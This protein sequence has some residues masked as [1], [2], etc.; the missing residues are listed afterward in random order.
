MF[1]AGFDEPEELPLL[2]ELHAANT[3]DTATTTTLS[4]RTRERGIMVSS[5]CG[6]GRPNEPSNL[7]GSP[8]G[9]NGIRTL[10]VVTSIERMRGNR[11]RRA[12]LHG[13]SAR[14]NTRKPASAISASATTSTT[15][16]YSI[17]LSL[18]ANPTVM[19]RPSVLYP[20]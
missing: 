14:C 18:L 7:P 19:K 4:A 5:F 10:L 16:P 8:P 9:G 11:Q 6:R 3:T 20:T 2:L 15:P 1:T 13:V 17:A 12:R